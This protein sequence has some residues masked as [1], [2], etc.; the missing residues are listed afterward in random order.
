[1]SF[2]RTRAVGRFDCVRPVRPHINQISYLNFDRNFHFAISS[3]LLCFKHFRAQAGLKPASLLVNFQ[4]VTK[5]GRRNFFVE[6]AKQRMLP[7]DS[8]VEKILTFRFSGA[9]GQVQ[10]SLLRSAFAF[11]TTVEMSVENFRL[12]DVLPRRAAW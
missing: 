4:H 9:A 6:C 7:F 5:Y 1:M 12:G 11:S 10:Y 2:C 8:V 3:L